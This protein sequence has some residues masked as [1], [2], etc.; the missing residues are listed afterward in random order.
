MLSAQQDTEKQKLTDKEMISKSANNIKIFKEIIIKLNG[1]LDEAKKE[2]D[3]VKVNSLNEK[4]ISAKALLKIAEQADK[5]LNIALKQQDLDRALREY[6]KVLICSKK[7]S[8]ILAESEAV[9]GRFI[10][11]TEL[12]E[13]I[14]G[15]DDN[16]DK[17]KQSTS[18]VEE[19]STPTTS[20][21][22]PDVNPMDIAPPPPPVLDKISQQ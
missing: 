8:I 21:N 4:L 18:T 17:D 16:Y 5:N 12:G 13:K 3:I 14:E 11:N 15:I 20:V 10:F 19:M 22:E 6:E 7:M 2:K 9:S 1:I